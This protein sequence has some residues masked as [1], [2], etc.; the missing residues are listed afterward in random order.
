MSHCISPV[1]VHTDGR[2]G[3]SA[4][5]EKTDIAAA[6]D[7]GQGIP[8]EVPKGDDEGNQ[9]GER[10]PHVGK[11]PYTPTK[12]EVEEHNPLHV[13]YRSWCPH[14]VAG[15]SISKQHRRQNA[16]EEALGVIVSIDYAFKVAEEVEE[17]TAPILIAYDHKTQAIWAI[18]VDHKG[19]DAG[20]G[21]AWLVERL[22]VA[23]YGGTKITIR[24]DQEVSIKALKMTIATMREAETALI[25]SPVRESKS[26]GNVERAVRNWRDQYRTMRHYV[27]HRMKTKIAN[28][29]PLSTWLVA[30]AADVINKF[31][32]RDNGRTAFE[33]MTQHRCKHLVVG[34]AERVHFQHT[35][36]DKNQYKKDVGMFL[37][38]NDR[39]NSFLIGMSEGIYAS[40]HVMKFS[41]DQAYDPTLIDDINVRFYDYLKGGVNAPP[42]VI[43][44]RAAILHPNPDV[45]PTPV[46]GGDYVP[47]RARITKEDLIK[48]G[49]TP[50]CP[51]CVAAQLPERSRGFRNHSEACRQRMSD[52]IPE[53]RQQ[54]AKD[55]L[56]NR[57]AEPGEPEV[58]KSDTA[59]PAAAV[60]DMKESSTG[61]QGSGLTDAERETGRD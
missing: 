48:H 25:E 27:E 8:G 18:E 40:P 57:T 41:E 9:L 16:Y 2:E 55:R 59:T 12:A 42:A 30:W 44:S 50:G 15:R 45:A 54:K 33:L 36:V 47:R 6:V 34:F 29:S 37:G 3:I 51:G 61:A 1:S 60:I 23:G 20:I 10:R 7:K 11:R 49:Y 52:L 5:G 32:V 17:E 21:A 26:N 39:C 22:Q 35:L 13:H 14:C 19:V 31:R 24:S 53:E 28:G 58:T 38:M 43:A 4:E 46:A 56:D